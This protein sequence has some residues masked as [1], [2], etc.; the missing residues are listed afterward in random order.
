MIYLFA[1]GCFEFLLAQLIR[2][3]KAHAFAADRVG[4]PAWA[5]RALGYPL[6]I[7]SSLNLITIS[8]IT[9]DM[10]VAALLYLAS[11]IM[12]RIQINPGRW[13]GFLLLGL[14]LGLLYLT[15]AVMFPLAFVILCVCLFS[16]REFRA[17]LP[18][19]LVSLLVFLLVGGPFIYAISKSKGRL[20]FGDSGKLAYI[21]F[22]DNVEPLVHWQ[23]NPV[24]S[25]TPAHPTRKILD[26]PE[27][28][29]F[30]TPFRVTYPAWYDP[31]YWYEG[32]K[33]RINLRGQFDVLWQSALRFQSIFFAP[34]GAITL[35]GFLMLQFYSART[36]RTLWKGS[37]T[38]LIV[39]ALA[40]FALY[41]LVYVVPRYLGGFLVL[42][43]LGLFSS[44]NL[45]NDLG[46]KRV[47]GSVIFGIAATSMLIIAVSTFP[48]ATLTVYHAVRGIKPPAFVYWEV[49]DGLRRKGL[50]PGDEIAGVD[51]HIS[52]NA[53]WARL[54]R[55]YVIAEIKSGGADVVRDDVDKFWNGGE[56]LRQKV[57]D[58]FAKTG[59]K[60][61]VADSVPIGF[62]DPR[63][64]RIG[65]TGHFVYF[66]R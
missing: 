26:N 4:L 47:I 35:A 9:P 1:F 28:Y 43:S 12:L 3:Q 62:S 30:R 15:K 34:I 32:V 65:N 23:G 50:Q 8:I 6:F 20:T 25:G 66:L 39:P 52:A 41:S 55:V 2:Y 60:A 7:W 48:T 31:T 64:Q 57:I 51:H 24:G 42:A 38:E 13:A 5:W 19:V 14:I 21:W 40:A 44:V 54:A 17:A 45:P 61:I 59:A 37:C 18:R 10:C 58:A 33:L 27:A 56:A 63:W 53:Y 16:A 49:A 36:L 46:S 22:V 29:E 11:G